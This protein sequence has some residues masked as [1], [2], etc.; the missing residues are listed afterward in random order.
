[1]S[2]RFFSIFRFAL[3]WSCSAESHRYIR[4]YRPSSSD[5]AIAAASVKS[6]DTVPARC[7]G[8]DDGDNL[9][10]RGNGGFNTRAL[11]R[12]RAGC[13]IRSC[14]CCV[15]R[16]YRQ[17][18]SWMREHLHSGDTVREPSRL[19]ARHAE[20]S[21]LRAGNSTPLCSS[22]SLLA[23]VPTN[24]FLATADVREPGAR[25]RGAALHCGEADTAGMSEHV[26]RFEHG[27]RADWLL[28]L[29]VFLLRS[30]CE[31]SGR[32]PASEPSGSGNVFRHFCDFVRASRVCFRFP[33]GFCFRIASLVDWRGRFSSSLG[34]LRMRLVCS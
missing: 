14:C 23:S 19:S 34:G 12:D 33:H 30:G 29:L 7:W 5:A 20:G 6:S 31:R 15:S 18:I 32:G 27:R 16:N 9:D 28:R 13:A 11:A 17:F 2:V 25:Q 26:E 21:I 22:A 10:A 8:S 1:M 24:L 4:S 3:H